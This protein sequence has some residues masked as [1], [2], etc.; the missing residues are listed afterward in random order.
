[1]PTKQKIGLTLWAILLI[2]VFFTK[3]HWVPLF[4]LL[5]VPF[6]IMGFG[7]R[8]YPRIGLPKKYWSV[9]ICLS[10]TLP[11]FVYPDQLQ[12]LPRQMG[13]APV[14][15]AAAL[16]L[17]LSRI[18][19]GKEAM[20]VARLLE[21][22]ATRDFCRQLLIM[23]WLLG[24]EEIMFRSFLV[25]L[26][27]ASWG[28]A[29]LLIGAGLFTYFHYF[30]RFASSLYR[31]KDYLYLALLSIALGVSFINGSGL[32]SC[33]FAHLAY[34]ATQWISLFIRHQNR[35]RT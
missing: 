24:A 32:I 29:S 15:V 11:L 7:M 6:L 26:A 13:W 12:I 9:P 5:G 1:M 34:N 10:L 31:T 27:P 33:V 18:R 3:F 30:N 21:P 2:T 8:I 4:F 35:I 17:L 19:E 22:I 16:L 28:L 20:Q 25:G 14:P 23:F